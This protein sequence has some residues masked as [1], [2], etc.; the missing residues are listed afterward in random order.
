MQSYAIRMFN[1]LRFGEKNNSLVFDL[2]DE[3]KKAL[4][5]GLITMDAIYDEVLKDPLKHI[6][7]VKKR[8]LEHV[9]GV[10]GSINGNPDCNNGS[11]KS[12]LLEGMCYSRY[13][14]V[15]RRSATNPDKV[16]KAGL[17]VVTKI[18]GDYPKGMTESWVEELSEANG[19]V[20]RIKRGR[21]F[22]KNHKTSTP[23]LEF[24]CIGETSTESLSSHRTTDTKEALENVLTMDYDLFVNSQMFGQNDA[25]KYLTGTDKTKK[26]MIISLLRLQNVVFACLEKIREKKSESN[27]KVDTLKVNIEIIEK[28]FSDKLSTFYDEVSKKNFLNPTEEE[29]ISW[30]SILIDRMET[31]LVS[32]KIR[33]EQSIENINKILLDIDNEINALSKSDE[34]TNVEKIKEEGRKILTEKKSKEKEMNDRVAEW[35]N[36]RSDVQ[37]DIERKNQ[38]ISDI[39]TR[40]DKSSTTLKVLE[41]SILAFKLEEQRETLSKCQKAKEVKPSFE[42]KF[43]KLS[44]IIL[45]NE[46]QKAVLDGNLSSAKRDLAKI[47]EITKKIS[48]DTK[49]NCPE[50]KS[51]VSKEHFF[52][53]KEEYQKKIKDCEEKSKVIKDFL[54]DLNT[55]YA[56]IKQK[57]ERIN[58]YI[59]MEPSV[60]FALKKYDADKIKVQELKDQIMENDSDSLKNTNEKIEQE[61]QM[62]KYDDKIKDVKESYAKNIAD[63][64]LKVAKLMVDVKEADEKAAKVKSQIEE[65]KNLK[66]T[67]IAEKDLIL[68]NIGKM[69]NDI[70]HFVQ[71]KHTLNIKRKELSDERKNLDRILVLEDVFGL[72]GIQT[73]IVKKYL[74]LLN[75]YIKEFLDILSN[76]EILVKM[77]INEK[78]KVDMNISG[79]TADSYEMLSGGEKMIIRLAVDIGLSLLAFSRTAQ[80]PELICLDEIFAPLDNYHVEKV[81]NILQ[82]LQDKFSRIIIISHKTEIKNRLK[83]NIIIEK[84]GGKGALSEIKRIE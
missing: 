42:D 14:K 69:A 61:K 1:F 16:E 54:T 73:R 34:I 71:Q 50:C 45:E 21:T 15:V 64:A 81:F 74:P 40:R 9:L 57:I 56:D 25:G 37:K 2:S 53:K 66:T 84:N 11:G 41:A 55:K 19:K 38:V 35:L 60:S 67:K 62:I 8:G 59:L 4:K 6:N 22:S 12:S 46:K 72:D 49:Y 23:L 29:I 68:G 58:K 27:K 48:G 75:V 77:L 70:E 51:L 33:Q 18:D 30:S 44:A 79:A 13:E 83:N 76:G 7:E 10:V 24:E 78:G 65:K 31:A 63:M 43:N 20:Y 5:N 32:Y 17:S 3:Q 28:Y 26:E 39:K 82:K 52:E 47:E 36:M 80:K